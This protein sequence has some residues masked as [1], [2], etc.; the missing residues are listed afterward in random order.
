MLD[1]L[2][3]GLADE[4]RNWLESGEDGVGDGEGEL[5]LGR[6][7]RRECDLVVLRRAAEDLV[8]ALAQVSLSL[9]NIPMRIDLDH[10][11]QEPQCLWLLL[12]LDLKAS[13]S[14]QHTRLEGKIV[15]GLRLGIDILNQYVDRLARVVL[16]EV[17]MPDQIHIAEVRCRLERRWEGVPRGKC[18]V[19][20]C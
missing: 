3:V 15:L 20:G 4:L 2:L 11:H 5:L 12:V 14:G 1:V 6:E 18:R 13:H 16:V 10:I 19:R 9:S 8:T 7:R 17:D